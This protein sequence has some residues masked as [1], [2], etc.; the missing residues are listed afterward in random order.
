M[1]MSFCGESTMIKISPRSHVIYTLP[2]PHVWILLTL[3]TNKETEAQNQAA[4]SL[5]L[6][7]TFFISFILYFFLGQKDQMCLFLPQPT[8]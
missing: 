5:S 7:E 3:F 8:F 2:K 4:K 6:D 1:E